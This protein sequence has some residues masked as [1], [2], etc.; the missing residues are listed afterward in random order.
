MRFWTLL[1]VVPLLSGTALAQELSAPR[2]NGA[3]GL[4]VSE[5]S[6]RHEVFVP[7]LYDDPMQ[8]NQ[9]ERDL[10]RDRNA[11]IKANTDRVRQGQTPLPMPAKKIASN[12]PVGSTP[13]LVPLGDEAPGNRNLP[14]RTQSDPSS[15]SVRYLYEAK[16]KNTGSKTIRS[17]TW[18]FSLFEPDTQTE[19]GRHVFKSD[20]KVREGKTVSLIG[21][22][23]NPPTR[24]VNV[25]KANKKIDDKYD[26]AVTIDL[27][28]YEDGTFWQR[29]STSEQPK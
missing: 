19:V 13:M 22:S 25:S 1:I 7:A 8:A 2:T 21:R 29:P 20:V 23:R 5:I 18:T 17:I 16:V 12:T 11:T 14:A 15:S 3:P 26:N 9:D 24:V 28:E 27:I 10:E 6:W 4:T